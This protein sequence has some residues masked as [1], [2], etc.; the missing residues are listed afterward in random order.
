[1]QPACWIEMPLGDYLRGPRL[2]D[3]NHFR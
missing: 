2:G 3:M 1:M